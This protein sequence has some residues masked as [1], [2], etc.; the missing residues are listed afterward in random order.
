MVWKPAAIGAVRLCD[1]SLQFSSITH[2]SDLSTFSL[3]SHVQCF[4]I[5]IQQSTH[6]FVCG[7]GVDTDAEL[8]NVVATFLQSHNYACSETIV[9]KMTKWLKS[10]YA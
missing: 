10:L 7:E 8:T 3:E 1:C 9:W 4:I 5:R 2:L 6:S